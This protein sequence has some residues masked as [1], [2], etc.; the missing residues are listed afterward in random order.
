MQNILKKFFGY[1]EFR[2]L[3]K[4]I[5]DHVLQQNDV[6]VLMPT[7][8]GK[9]LCYQIPALK[10]AG[11]TIVVSPLISLMKDQVDAL[12][13]NGV[14]A[15]YWNSSLATYEL[16]QIQE[17]LKNDHLKL[18]YLAP[19]RL[20][21]PEFQDFLRTLPISLFAIDEA[22]CI[23]E[24]GHDFRKDYRILNQ[25]KNWFPHIPLIA[26][27]ATATQKVREDI[28][29]QLQ[30]PQAQVFQSSFERA[31]LEIQVIKKVKAWEKLLN[32]L[33]NYQQESVIIYCFSRKDTED[34]CNKLKHQG[35]SALP[36]H[37]GLSPKQRQQNQEDFIQ[38]KVNI[39]V[40]T[41][42]FG[43]GI[44]KPDVRLVIHYTYPKSLE[45][46]YQ[47]IGR[48]GRDGLPSKCILFFTQADSRKHEFFIDQVLDEE[49]RTNSR[50]KLQ[51]MINYA[52]SQKCRTQMLLNYFAET[53]IQNCGHCDNCELVSQTFDASE[54]SLKIFS[55][56]IRTGS[57]FGINYI[58]QL[59]LAKKNKQIMQNQHQQLSVYGIVQ[60]F[61]EDALKS[62][63]QSLIEQ[64]YLVKS[65]GK[66]PVLSLSLKGKMAL[67]DSSPIFL[68]QPKI[69]LPLL[70]SKH[71]TG[72]LNY[73]LETFEE[74]R[75]LRKSC[76]IERKIAPFMVFSDKT[77]QEMAYYLPQ[78][79]QDLKKIHGIG[80]VKIDSFG[81]QF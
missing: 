42:A 35:F 57:R 63:I 70:D 5:I 74:L 40:A 39:M 36:Y 50:K 22:H 30:I 80:Q 6:F 79:Y 12:N 38:D 32:I 27:T 54:I 15:A 34:L 7:G 2:P 49:E 69:D 64:E 1:E 31:N 29:K 66:Y 67:K 48:A 56:I 71:K 68:A 28:L 37:A 18:L 73:H 17:D 16:E 24:W 26:L 4:E 52:Q 61:S 43:M 78:N 81:E 19:E 13:E 76:A 55:A 3:Q 60:N 59:L 77:L 51:M 75:I 8:G 25:L 10:L 9:S 72:V 23:S 46:Y 53:N 65:E 33:K 41:I 11:L 62:I 20:A 14:A 45:N 47:E 58:S 21:I 44:D